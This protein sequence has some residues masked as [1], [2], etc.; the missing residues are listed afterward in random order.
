MET[1]IHVSKVV[2]HLPTHFFATFQ[3]GAE[4]ITIK[5]DIAYLG[6]NKPAGYRPSNEK[7]D[8]RLIKFI[9]GDLKAYTQTNKK[10]QSHLPFWDQ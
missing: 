5:F 7:E 8:H 1:E 10:L 3:R 9:G 2:L 4:K 6:S